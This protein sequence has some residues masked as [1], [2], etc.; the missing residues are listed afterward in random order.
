MFASG[1]SSAE[2]LSV[3]CSVLPSMANGTLEAGF[4][5]ADDAEGGFSWIIGFLLGLTGTAGNVLVKICWRYHHINP[6]TRRGIWIHR[7]GTVLVPMAATADTAAFGF[8]PQ[9]LCAATAGMAP[10]F[11]LLLAPKL[12]GESW[13]SKDLVGACLVVAGCAGVGFTTS[14]ADLDGSYAE[15][16]AMFSSTRFIAFCAGMACYL[17][18]LVAVITLPLPSSFDPDGTFALCRKLAWG[19]LGGSVSGFLVFTSV[20]T[21]FLP[22]STG[23]RQPEATEPCGDDDPWGQPKSW[24]IVVFPA[25][26][27]AIIGVVLLE[28]ALS[29]YS[30]I[31]ITPMYQ[32][33]FVLMGAISGVCSTWQEQ[34][35]AAHTH[36]LLSGADLVLLFCSPLPLANTAAECACEVQN[37]LA[38]ASVSTVVGFVLSLMMLVLGGCCSLS[39]R[40]SDQSVTSPRIRGTSIDEGETAQGQLAVET[41]TLGAKPAVVRP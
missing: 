28:R 1:L 34:P 4:D 26:S 17:A 6:D 10:V 38:E 8:A 24:A 20:G 22:L 23:C 19:C 32:S 21:R 36:A 27:V 9:A 15:L 16:M 29:R 11:N 35:L 12:L 41:E 37:E 33:S 31:Y 14:G 30:A 18:F 2:C 40:N 13:T 3:H 7:L 39:E 25:L 5:G